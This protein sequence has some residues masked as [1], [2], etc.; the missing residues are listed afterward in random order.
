MRPLGRSN[1]VGCQATPADRT[2]ILTC[3]VYTISVDLGLSLR[4]LTA[5]ANR[6]V[7]HMCGVLPIQR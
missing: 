6:T 7:I 2:K 5:S 4:W 1:L 3:G